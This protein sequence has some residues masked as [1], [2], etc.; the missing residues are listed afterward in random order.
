M[1]QALSTDGYGTGTVGNNTG[2]SVERSTVLASDKDDE[3]AKAIAEELGGLPISTEAGLGKGSVR[4]VLAS[5]YAGPGS[6]SW[7]GST[8]SD[9]TDSDT[10][11]SD[12]SEPS[13]SPTPVP[14]APPIDAG[15][16]GPK[17]VN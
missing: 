11:E 15:E 6:D 2:D 12:S 1:S 10:T 4:V 5:D 14:P 7:T 17:C 13:T 16:G 3:A 8:G 9:N